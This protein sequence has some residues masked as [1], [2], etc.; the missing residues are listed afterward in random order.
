MAD[1]S[2]GTVDLV[3]FD[4]DGVLVDSEPIAVPI[5]GAALRTLGLVMTDA[6]VHRTFV[7]FTS[8]RCIEIAEE[9][10]GR[11][12]PADFAERVQVRTFKAFC[13]GLRAMPGIVE[14]LDR[15]PVPYCVASS[16]DPGKMRLTLGLTGLL[17]R[18]RDRMFSASEVARGKPS[19][20][21]FLHAAERSGAR[22]DR[23]VVVEDSL[24][25]VIAAAAAG[26]RVQGYCPTGEGAE[27]VAAGAILFRDLREL[28]ER[29]VEVQEGS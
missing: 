7:G 4:C 16:G 26:M 8:G 20:D 15:L 25:G 28:P 18:F 2:G 10:L 11:A 14:T 5:L 17:D 12:L 29:L 21:L 23:T 24:P 22:P 19:P 1:S 13:A 27:L 9:R 3:V 6:E